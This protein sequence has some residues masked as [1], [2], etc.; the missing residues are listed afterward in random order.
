MN[1]SRGRTA[2]AIAATAVLA[3]ALVTWI[4]WSIQSAP[5]PVDR[6]SELRT[7]EREYRAAVAEHASAVTALETAASEATVLA[8]QLDARAAA[9]GDAGFAEAAAQLRSA[10]PT[11]RPAPPPSYSRAVSD[12]SSDAD[13]A[14]AV[15]AT[16]ALAEEVRSEGSAISDASALV[17]A[18][19][20][21]AEARVRAVV[22]EQRVQV[23]TARDAAQDEGVR[24]TLDQF[25][26]MAASPTLSRSDL[27]GL[28]DLFDSLTPFLS[29]PVHDGE[30]PT[31]TSEP[32]L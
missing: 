24:A 8:D 21:D 11:E 31:G 1:R 5:P 15:T 30:D 32:G 20:A 29:P 16:L 26:T 22:D 7:A 28:L 25:A 6:L 13:I 12:S 4:V 2:V 3:A 17:T 9:R 27:F 18:Q 23:E 14:A 10:T 19:I